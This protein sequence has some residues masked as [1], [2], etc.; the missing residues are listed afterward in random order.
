MGTTRNLHGATGI[1]SGYTS[2]Y[3]QAGNMTCRALTSAATCSGTPTGAQLTYDNEGRLIA[4]QNTPSNPTSTETIAYDGEGHAVARQTNGGTPTY[5]LSTL[6]EIAGSMLTKYFTATGLPTIVRNGTGGALSYLMADAQDSLEE[7][8]GG[9]G[10]VT[11]QQLYSPYGGVR[12][13][14]G[15][16]PT[17]RFYTGQLWDAT[18]GLYF[19]VARYYDAIAHQFTSADTEEDGLNRFGYV[20][21][22]PETATDPTGHWYYVG[23]ACPPVFTTS[24]HWWGMS[25]YMNECTIQVM[26][27]LWGFVPFVAGALVAACAYWAAQCVSILASVGIVVAASEVGALV[28]VIVA[29]VLLVVAGYVWW[30]NH[31]DWWCGY[32]G[33]FIDQSWWGWEW[34]GTIC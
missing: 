32:K 14:S 10:S 21:G 9:G 8:V 4:W 7:A 34:V 26:N 30:I 15:S 29:V 1:G 5:Y 22:N 11:F 24:W 31:D 33:V 2:S 23:P 3:D 20:A 19:Y 25:H 28:A 6:E 27:N 16:A 18:A 17:L 13:S 12:Y